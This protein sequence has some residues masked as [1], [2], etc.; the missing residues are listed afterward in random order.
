MQAMLMLECSPPFQWKPSYRRAGGVRRMMWA[1]FAIA[2]VPGGFNEVVEGHAYAGADLY[3]IGELKGYKEASVEELRAAF[4]VTQGRC[5]HGDNW[6]Y[7]PD[8]CH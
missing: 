7:C 8:C 3:R 4:N 2:Y 5:P 1:W 6:D